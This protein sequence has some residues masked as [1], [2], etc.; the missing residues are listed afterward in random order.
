MTGFFADKWNVISLQL[1]GLGEIYILDL[2]S[3]ARTVLAVW[4]SADCPQRNF[5]LAQVKLE[6]NCKWLCSREEFGS[7]TC[8]KIILIVVVRLSLQFHWTLR[9]G[10]LL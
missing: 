1:L 2:T 9:C 3:G 7:S 5:T 4:Y 8:R 6:V 10:A